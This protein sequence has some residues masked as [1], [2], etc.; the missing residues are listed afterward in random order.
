MFNSVACSSPVIVQLLQYLK[1]ILRME[2]SKYDK[3]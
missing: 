1:K 3:T 2:F